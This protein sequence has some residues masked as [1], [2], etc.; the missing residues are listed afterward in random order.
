M[1]DTKTHVDN[2]QAVDRLLTNRQ[3]ELNKAVAAAVTAG[4]SEVIQPVHP[5]KLVLIDENEDPFG[6]NINNRR[7]AER[8]MRQRGK[9]YGNT[10]IP[11]HTGDPSKAARDVAKSKEINPDPLGNSDEEATVEA[12]RETRLP[13]P[14]S[15]AA[16]RQAAEAAE[17]NPKVAKPGATTVAQTAA[18]APV[19]ATPAAWTPPAVK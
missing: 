6:G 5:S 12:K 1:I 19:T 11:T 7:V 3:V 2:S 17:D 8:I 16:N 10:H 14:G 4:T 9:N 15:P 18:A 13:A